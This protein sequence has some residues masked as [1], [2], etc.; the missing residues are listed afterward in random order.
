MVLAKIQRSSGQCAM[1]EGILSLSLL[2]MT[3]VLSEKEEGGQ[4][5]WSQDGE[6]GGGGGR[7]GKMVARC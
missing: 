1:D 3:N 4:A 5:R 2:F 7:A 6:D